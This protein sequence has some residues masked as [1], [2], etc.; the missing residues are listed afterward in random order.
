MYNL[1]DIIYRNNQTWICTK[2]EIEEVATFKNIVYGFID[3]ELR[4][5][6]MLNGEIL[7]REFVVAKYPDG[8]KDDKTLFIGNDN[9]H[10]V[11]GIADTDCCDTPL[12]NIQVIKQYYPELYKKI[13]TSEFNKL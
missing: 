6:E 10:P 4:I 3:Q 12:W 11:I 9:V 13:I 8:S 7:Q 5:G 1:K 2:S